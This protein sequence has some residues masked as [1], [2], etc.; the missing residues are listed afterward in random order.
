MY[1]F[2]NLISETV[3]GCGKMRSRTDAP[4]VQLDMLSSIKKRTL[5]NLI[6]ATVLCRAD[7]N[8]LTHSLILLSLFVTDPGVRC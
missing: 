3:S 1:Q 7:S 5:V 8:S 4:L 2:R 6:Q